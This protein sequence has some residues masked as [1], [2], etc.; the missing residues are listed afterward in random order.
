MDGD[1]W[2]SIF[3]Y[4]IFPRFLNNLM[5]NAF[6]TSIHF[7]GYGLDACIWVRVLCYASSLPLCPET[8]CGSLSLYPV[9]RTGLRISERNKQ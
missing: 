3:W 2:E 5:K 8:P 1:V 9:S 6:V 4:H 7:A